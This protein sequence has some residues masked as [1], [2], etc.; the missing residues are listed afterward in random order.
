[1]PGIQNFLVDVFTGYE[2]Y[3]AMHIVKIA[4]HPK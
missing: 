4:G 1:M 2:F 3:E